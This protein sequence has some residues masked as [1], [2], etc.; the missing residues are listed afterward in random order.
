MK[1]SK[2][3]EQ[4]SV[5]SDGRAGEVL[6]ATAVEHPHRGVVDC[7]AAPLVAA[8]LRRQG[9]RVRLRAMTVSPG[10]AGD[11]DLAMTSYIGHDGRAVGVAAA[12]ATGSSQLQAVRA[13]VAEWSE[14]FRTRRVLVDDRRPGCAGSWRAADLLDHAL[15]TTDGPVFALG[16][17]ATDPE[18]GTALA[19]RGLLSI[20]DP[21]EV[22]PGATLVLP[23]S[24]VAAAV[25][26]QAA[27]RLLRVVDG[28][29]PLV[30]SVRDESRRRAADG[31]VVLVAGR[32]GHAA[33][34]GLMTQVPGAEVRLVE[35][36]ADVA[37]LPPLD[38]AGV[39]Y[40]VQPGVDLSDLAP[41]LT[42]LRVRFP[43]LRGPH[44]D[45]WCYAATDRAQSARFLAAHADVVLVCGDPSAP[46]TADLVGL[47]TAAGGRA[48]IVAEVASIR[49]ESLLDASTVG[50]LTAVS[51][52]RAL[53]DEV[54]TVLGGLGPLSVVR[55]TISTSVGHTASGATA[56]PDGATPQPASAAGR[57]AP[58]SALTPAH[59]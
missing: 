42:A 5:P 6:V 59:H 3:P 22:P 47:V 23:A 1:R 4:W 33:L 10:S 11:L 49:A 36:V 26:E 35:T 12:A 38:P 28:T 21:R 34:P 55:Q 44:P 14:V 31:D 32:S 16:E 54:I 53:A 39:S 18:S 56:A 7:A 15:A 25:R 40:V 24:G 13:A 37:A 43:R 51:A 57:G 48:E 52:P 27:A 58:C 17:F 41:V 50:L 30:S 20:V 19:R 8:S 9:I 2:L 45:Q 46:D 29:C